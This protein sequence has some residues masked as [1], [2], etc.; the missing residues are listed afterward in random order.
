MVVRSLYRTAILSVAVVSTFLT[1]HTQTHVGATQNDPATEFIDTS[2]LRPPQ[3]VNVA[4]IEWEDMECPFCAKAF[5]LVHAA[6]KS[7][8]VTLVERDFLIASHA[9]SP[10]AALYSRYLHDKESPDLAAEYR[11]EIFASQSA[12]SSKDD[13]LEM[14]RRFFAKNGKQIPLIVDPNGQLKKEISFDVELGNKVGLRHTPTIV[15]ATPTHWTEVL[16]PTQIDQVIAD[17]QRSVDRGS[18]GKES[19]VK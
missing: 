17:A 18:N 2:L 4:V 1:S 12:I 9:W 3:G 8:H 11:R 19:A 16:D 7:R 15:V 5:P 10:D 6:V 13:L 14:T